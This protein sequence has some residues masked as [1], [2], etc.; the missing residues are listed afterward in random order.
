LPLQSGIVSSNK[1]LLLGF[2]SSII[3]ASIGY[4]IRL[5]ILNNL[6]YD[7]LGINSKITYCF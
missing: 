1:S 4:L 2:V 7:I 3:T 6:E 5:V